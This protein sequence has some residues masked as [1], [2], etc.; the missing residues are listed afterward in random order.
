MN[1]SI[2][3]SYLYKNV[4]FYQYDNMVNVI[5]I[6]Y[7]IKLDINKRWDMMDEIKKIEIKKHLIKTDITHK[8]PYT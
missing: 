7:I 2:Y 4:N 1:V 5:F 3:I 6:M 8:M